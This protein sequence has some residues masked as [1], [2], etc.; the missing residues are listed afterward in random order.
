MRCAHSENTYRNFLARDH[1]VVRTGASPSRSLVKKFHGFFFSTLRRFPTRTV[2][3]S[4]S[5]HS[6]I[7]IASLRVRPNF[8]LNSPTA[9]SSSSH[10]AIGANDLV[11]HRPV[12]E[13]SPFEPNEDP[14]LDQETADAFDHR[15][16]F[17][18]TLGGL[19][20]RGWLNARCTVEVVELLAQIGPIGS[21]VAARSRRK[22]ASVG[23]LDR[24]THPQYLEVVRSK[25]ARSNGQNGRHE[26]PCRNPR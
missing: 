24:L 17:T 22:Y 5:S 7:G 20:R 18:E 10:S 9:K 12:N 6:R 4:E 3:R 23:H 8:C 16:A 11:E 14:L 2:T 26:V 13:P 15:R 19:P 21:H 1:L 25:I